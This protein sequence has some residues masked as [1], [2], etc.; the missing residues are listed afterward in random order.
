MSTGSPR[1]RAFPFKVVLDFESFF[2]DYALDCILNVTLKSPDW[3][4][5]EVTAYRKESP[6]HLW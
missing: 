4:D 1:I 5:M 2:C 3:Y 6:P